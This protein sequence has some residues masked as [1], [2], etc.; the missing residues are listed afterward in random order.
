MLSRLGL[1]ESENDNILVGLI[2]VSPRFVKSTLGVGESENNIFLVELT[3]TSPHFVKSTFWGRRLQNDNVVGK[4]N[5]DS[6]QDV[7]LTPGQTDPRESPFRQHD[8]GGRFL[9]EP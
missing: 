5:L 9:R 3:L 2:F 1:N 7:K 8:F 4:E 6:K